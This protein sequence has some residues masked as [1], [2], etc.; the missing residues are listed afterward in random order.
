MNAVTTYTFVGES[1]SSFQY[2]MN[3]AKRIVC[4]V[5]NT[6]KNVS[7]SISELVKK[8]MQLVVAVITRLP[9]FSFNTI[10]S[11]I[12]VIVALSV[13]GFTAMGALASLI[14]VFAVGVIFRMALAA[15]LHKKGHKEAAGVFITAIMI[16][17]LAA[18]FWQMAASSF[19]IFTAII[20]VENVYISLNVDWS[21]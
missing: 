10:F 2:R 20:I 13:F 15:K 8:S 17:M 12:A 18:V 16:S 3:Q 11:I 7:N 1:C 4:N 9:L 6:A 14:G 5:I 21:F 19:I